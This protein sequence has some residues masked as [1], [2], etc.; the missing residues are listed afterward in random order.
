MIRQLAENK[1]SNR[2]ITLKSFL[3]PNIPEKAR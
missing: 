3:L 1:K 2:K